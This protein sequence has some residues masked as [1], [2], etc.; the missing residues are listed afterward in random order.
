[1]DKMTRGKKIDEHDIVYLKG[2]ALEAVMSD[3][4]NLSHQEGDV[5]SWHKTYQVFK[6][7][8]QKEESKQ[9][10]SLY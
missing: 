5:K 3:T 4:G 7:D 6:K 8:V 1:M 2:D 9:G 10:R